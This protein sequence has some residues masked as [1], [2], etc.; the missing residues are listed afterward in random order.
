MDRRTSFSRFVEG[1]ACARVPGL[2]CA[3]VLTWTPSVDAGS[4]P[5]PSGVTR[6][7]TGSGADNNWNTDANWDS[8]APD[9]GDGLTFSGGSDTISNNNLVSGTSPTA[10]NPN[11]GFEIVRILFDN[12]GS[13]SETG[14]FTLTGNSVRVGTASGNDGITTAGVSGTSITDTIALDLQLFANSPNGNFVDFEIN[15]NHDLRIDG[16]VYDGTG[17]ESYVRKTGDG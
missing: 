15:S 16:V 11:P 6:D 10:S 14:S 5:T 13:P 12:D 17:V 3:T 7:W 4:G 9:G 2:L 8:G 1:T